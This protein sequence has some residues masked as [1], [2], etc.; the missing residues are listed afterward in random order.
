M[1]VLR[2][3]RSVNLKV[4]NIGH[5][6]EQLLRGLKRKLKR[7]G[8]MNCNKNYTKI[9][10]KLNMFTN[11]KD[12]TPMENKCNVVCEF[13]C[14]KCCNS[15]IL[16]TLLL[17]LAVLP[18]KFPRIRLRLHYGCSCRDTSF[19][20]GEWSPFGA[21]PLGTLTIWLPEAISDMPSL[22]WIKRFNMKL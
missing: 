15:Y 22:N 16:G 17:K 4:P 13:T 5:R 6:G 9:Y 19:W 1:F 7:W 10:Y 18:S 14:Q 11:V 2:R 21:G 3:C 12:K 8:L 20:W